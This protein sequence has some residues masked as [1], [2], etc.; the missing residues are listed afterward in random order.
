MNPMK[1]PRGWARIPSYAGSQWVWFP[2]GMAKPQRL[3]LPA[4][5]NAMYEATHGT[6]P[7]YAVD[8]QP[9]F[10]L[11]RRTDDYLTGAIHAWEQLGTYGSPHEGVA[12]ARADW[13]LRH[14]GPPQANPA[15]KK[16]GGPK[17]FWYAQK[18]RFVI[19]HGA[20]FGYPSRAGFRI[21]EPQGQDPRPRRRSLF[22]YYCVESGPPWTLDLYFGWGS[23]HGNVASEHLG[24]YSSK[25]DLEGA[26]RADWALRHFA[27]TKGNPVPSK[28]PP[29]KK[30]QVPGWK[31]V[32]FAQVG[33]PGSGIWDWRPT[34]YE[35][36]LPALYRYS[37]GQTLPP[38]V[39]AQGKGK[40]SL[41]FAARGAITAEFLGFYA[42][43]QEAKKAAKVHWKVESSL[44]QFAPAKPNRKKRRRRR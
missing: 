7:A 8:C 28:K 36:R 40:G 2:E 37:E 32:G 10:M 14:F 24:T 12:A 15:R 41:V 17:L 30:K 16:N 5:L 35:G 44:G 39:Q 3:G 1:P 22:R 25:E 9:P 34:R 21:H 6:G 33:G 26:V 38:V 31:Q 23:S 42:T 4:D 18:G 43:L 20:P 13:A 19:A 11:Q 27:P 29:K